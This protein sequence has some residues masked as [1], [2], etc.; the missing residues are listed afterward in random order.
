MLQIVRTNE[1]D[2]FLAYFPQFKELYQNVKGNYEKLAQRLDKYQETLSQTQDEN[3]FSQTLEKL[4]P[5][6]TDRMVLRKVCHP[7]H[8]LTVLQA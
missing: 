8:N 7:L 4:C 5:K 6:G 2:E 1:G 3:Q